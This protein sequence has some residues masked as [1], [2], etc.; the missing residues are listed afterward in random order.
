[1]K[2]KA[3]LTISRPSYANGTKNVLITVQDEDARIEFLEVEISYAD[4]TECLTGLA[5][6]HCEMKVTGLEN[7]GKMREVRSLE[8]KMPLYLDQ[9]ARRK[10]SAVAEAILHTP[11]GWKASA[12]YGS[13]D[14]FFW[15]DNEEWARTTIVRWWVDK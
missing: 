14:S 15:K 4:F 5:N 6:V 10:E 7:V 12:Y 9:Q 11:E 2:H 3:K 13:K 1:M 8:F